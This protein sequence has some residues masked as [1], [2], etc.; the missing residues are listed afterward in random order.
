MAERKVL[1]LRL[2]PAL[3][4]ALRRWAADDFRSVN[5]QVEYVIHRA[6]R[7]AGRLPQGESE[8]QDGRSG[9][10]P[11]RRDGGPSSRSG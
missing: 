5:G 10:E 2:R 4:E 9:G 8:R 1:L 7:D 3:Y 6:L 11:R